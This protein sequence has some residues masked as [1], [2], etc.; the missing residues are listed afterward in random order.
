[1]FFVSLIFQL[2]EIERRSSETTAINEAK[3]REA[4][5]EVTLLRDQ[6]DE[7]SAH[8]ETMR[9]KVKTLKAFHEKARSTNKRR[10]G[11]ASAS[12][13][14]SLSLEVDDRGGGGGL[15]DTDNEYPLEKKMGKFHLHLG[16]GCGDVTMLSSD[17]ERTLCSP[18]SEYKY[19]MCYI[20]DLLPDPISSSIPLD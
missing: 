5:E 9:E 4:H 14:K 13:S 6:N 7:L 11:S 19:T 3:L 16:P 17:G 10:K 15:D 12:G 20:I 18:D 1:M 2:L 8:V